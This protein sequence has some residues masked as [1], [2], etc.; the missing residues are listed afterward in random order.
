MAIARGSAAPALTRASSL[1]AS[2]RA[3]GASGG[4]ERATW[5]APTR[6]PSQWCSGRRQ[7][8]TFRSTFLAA[9]N[10][11]SAQSRCIPL[12]DGGVD[13]FGGAPRDRR[14]DEPRAVHRTRP[15]QLLGAPRLPAPRARARRGAR[16]GAL[17]HGPRDP[18]ADGRAA[19]QR[20][21]ARA[22][23]RL[24]DEQEARRRTSG[25]GADPRS[26][27]RE[28]LERGA[29]RGRSAG[30][31]KHAAR[32]HQQDLGITGVDLG[33]PHGRGLAWLAWLE[34]RDSPSGPAATP[35]A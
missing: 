8:A 6:V 9:T 25:A 29:D 35:I 2:S 34:R 1:I 13:A 23:P 30:S 24:D 4:T 16:A 33:S 14:A 22:L 28:R 11:A 32:P 20:V 26:A 17:E 15:G 21:G 31:S 7:A 3:R 5:N 18:L 12:E 10:C 19:A 27:R